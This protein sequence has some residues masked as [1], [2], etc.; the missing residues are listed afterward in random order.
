MDEQFKNSENVHVG[1]GHPN[2]GL[3]HTAVPDIKSV[4]PNA[5]MDAVDG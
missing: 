3:F 1:Y 4:I 5:I 2:L